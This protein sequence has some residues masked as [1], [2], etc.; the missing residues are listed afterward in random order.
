MRRVNI[1][2]YAAVRGAGMTVGGAPGALAEPGGGYGFSFRDP[3]GRALRIVADAARHAGSADA[4]NRP[5]RIA[6]VVLNSPDIDASSAFYLEV[7]GFG[8]R[9]RSRMM[10]FLRCNEDH[11]SIAFFKAADSTLNHVAFVMRDVAAILRGAERLEEGGFA[12]DWGIGQHGSG[13]PVFAYFVGPDD[14][15]IE[16]TTEV[17]A[18]WA[19]PP[20]ARKY[21]NVAKSQ[22]ERFRTAQR[23][24]AW[25]SGLLPVL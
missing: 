5:S 18:D 2:D 14:A 10:N 25:A 8:M 7:L 21:W 16:Y 19:C 23:R 12:L 13:E 6:H 15:V 1:V 22:T 17:D 24:V 3:D 4:E 9:E 20:A 11:H